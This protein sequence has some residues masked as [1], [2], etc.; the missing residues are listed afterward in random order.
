MTNLRRWIV[1]LLMVLVVTM[2]VAA[3]CLY[4]INPFG[5]RSY[6]P[7]QRIIGYAPYRIPSRSM[8]P[9]LNPDQ[10]VVMRAGYYIKHQPQR[11]DIVIFLSPTDGNPWVKRVIGL[12]GESI[13]ID[14]G[15]VLING[16]RIVENYV[17]IENAT[18][19][20][21]RNMSVQKVP[22]SSYFLLGDNRD[23]S[24]DGR[25]LGA[26]HRDD[27]IGKVTVIFK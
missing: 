18:I 9:T 3:I 17:A 24:E 7:R 2:P 27:L 20:Y 1:G 6:D 16:K 12:P 4:L 5:A 22:D 15:V 21:S 11:G 23:N 25:I 26:T 8:A 10:I 13:A 19:D 14:E